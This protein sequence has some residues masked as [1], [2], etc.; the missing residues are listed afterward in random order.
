MKP[1]TVFRR[2]RRAAVL[3]YFCIGATDN[4]YFTNCIPSNRPCRYNFRELTCY[5]I[6]L[7][8]KISKNDI[9]KSYVISRILTF[10]HLHP[11]EICFKHATSCLKIKC[12]LRKDFNSLWNSIIFY[13]E[14][15]K[16]VLNQINQCIRYRYN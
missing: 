3:S 5:V 10:I 1:S 2:R 13:F 11:H 6:V 16:S 14:F 9:V 8:P 7:Y 4:R 15:L 12:K